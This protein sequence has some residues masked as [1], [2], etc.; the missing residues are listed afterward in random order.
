[1]NLAAVGVLAWLDQVAFISLWCAWAALTSVAI[2]VHLRRPDHAAD[3]A[4]SQAK[5]DV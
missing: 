2:A 4:P 5:V 3:D 1:M